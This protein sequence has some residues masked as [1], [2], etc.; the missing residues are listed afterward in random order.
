MALGQGGS[1]GQFTASSVTDSS[2]VFGITGV[3]KYGTL[4]VAG[5]VTFDTGGALGGTL[6][7]NDQSGKTAQNPI[8][9]TG[10]WTVDPTGRVTLTN[11]TDGSTFDYSMHAYLT[12]NGGGLLLSNDPS[13]TGS[14]QA[15]QQQAGTLTTAS[16]SGSYG[17]NA[18]QTG[19]PYMAQSPLVIGSVTAT[20]SNNMDSVAG[21]AD[22]A[23][24]GSDYAISGSFT[25]VT[26]G[27][28]PGATDRPLFGIP[29]PTDTFALYLDD[30]AQAVVIE[31]GNAE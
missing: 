9:F 2:Y 30:N 27:V 25:S 21:F 28:V 3:D 14:G 10:S 4:Q 20:P 5:V 29:S 22:S 8:P 31:T 16:F 13:E 23:N 11:L 26:N 19:N 7:W 6:N 24:G 1:T 17:I 12:G 18:S 15:Y